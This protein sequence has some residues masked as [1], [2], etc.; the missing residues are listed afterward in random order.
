MNPH[1]YDLSIAAGHQ[2]APSRSYDSCVCM[3]CEAHTPGVRPC[4]FVVLSP[5]VN[6]HCHGAESVCG[7]LS[8]QRPTEV[9]SWRVCPLS[10]PAGAV[11]LKYG[12]AER[13]RKRTPEN[14]QL[15][16]WPW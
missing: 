8:G 5:H 7:L 13:F 4:R 1:R 2:Q 16:D 11:I 3:V 14:V 10:G 15:L 12:H 6:R 9:Q